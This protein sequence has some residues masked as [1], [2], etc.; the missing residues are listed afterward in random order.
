MIVQQNKSFNMELPDGVLAYCVLKSA[1]LSTETEKLAR[2]TIKELTYKN[3][4]KQLRKI[5][6][7][8]S[9]SQ[10]CKGQQLAMKTE[11]TFEITPDSEEAFYSNHSQGSNHY[12]G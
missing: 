8:I 2:A 9:A 4:S 7:D 3:I 6:V 11:P 5:F 12:H 10:K 1:N